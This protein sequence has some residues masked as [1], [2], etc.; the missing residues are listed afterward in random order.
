MSEKPIKL[1]NACSVMKKPVAVS[2]VLLVVLVLS[3]RLWLSFS[4]SGL[5]SDQSY[6]HV[7]NVESILATGKP[8]FED[9]L[10]W[11][12]R[13][14]VFSPVFDYVIALFALFMS[15]DVAAKFV[16][17]LFG[18]LLVVI[19]YLL[20]KR[21]TN[22]AGVSLFTA[23]LSA[24]V[25]IWLQETL[26]QLTPITLVVP[27]M[28]FLLYALLRIHEPRWLMIYVVTLAFTA[29]VHP[30]SMLL[31]ITLAVYLVLARVEGIPVDRPLL[32]VSLFSIFFILWVQFLMY[33]KLLFIHGLGIIWQNIPSSLLAEI[34]SRVS[35][36]GAI[37][38]VG[39]VPLLT[40]AY[41]AYRYVFAVQ[42]KELSLVM[43]FGLATGLLLSFRLLEP[44]QGLVLLSFAGIVL[45][46]YA[47]ALFI[48]FL[49]RT[50][51][52]RMMPLIILL[53]CVFALATKLW[54]ASIAVSN[55]L[56]FFPPEEQRAMEWISRV[57]TKDATVVALAEE[58]QR[59]NAVAKRKSMIDSHFLG[60]VDASQR[61][62]DLKRIFL[63]SI[64]LEAVEIF[65]KYDADYL[66]VSSAVQQSFGKTVPRYMESGNCFNLV[67]DQS[68]KIY[69]KSPGCTVRVIT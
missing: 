36:I 48:P 6:W 67:Y 21:L 24:L 68:A 18:A 11:N 2:L 1:T 61:A 31:A 64:E 35:V 56:E 60:R 27:L 42:Y 43:S 7:R 9:S 66:Y 17:A 10:A 39:I 55:T 19:V 41:L 5:S 58:G 29:F 57:T 37:A 52:S 62:E 16:P 65:D 12:G 20:A 33:K 53:W 50:R 22:H 30:L 14:V 28:G 63:S 23:L 34:F 54:P 51:F 59:I 38:Q 44:N 4:V 69:E 49:Q 15:V 47:F 46:A 26:N 3:V 32:E 13:A 8:L 40:A 25:P 45:F